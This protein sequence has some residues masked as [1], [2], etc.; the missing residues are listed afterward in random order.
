MKQGLNF[1]NTYTVNSQF[2][3]TVALSVTS[4]SSNVHL[5]LSASLNNYDVIVQNVG[6]KTAFIAFGNTSAITA[7]TPTAGLTN[8]F[9]VLA[10]AIYTLQKNSDAQKNDWCAGICGG[11]DT[12]TLYFTAIQ[13]S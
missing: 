11:T 10:G 5:T 9:P 7:G 13:G 1:I 4:T 3:E 6:T 8:A 12:T 2:G